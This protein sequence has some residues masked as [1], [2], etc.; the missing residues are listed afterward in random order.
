MIYNLQAPNV[1]KSMRDLMSHG[2]P[3]GSVIEAHGLMSAEEGTLQ[4]ARRE[5]DL[6]GQTLHDYQI[7]PIGWSKNSFLYCVN[8]VSTSF[9]KN[10]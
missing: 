9:L 1:I 4:N 10:A 5:S 6:K 7:L 2:L 3:N 8:K